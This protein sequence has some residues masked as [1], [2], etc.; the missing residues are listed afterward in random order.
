MKQIL[1]LLWAAALLAHDV[2]AG[3]A[4]SGNAWE[5]LLR[6]DARIPATS[7]QAGR[8][9]DARAIGG[10][11]ARYSFTVPAE[12]FAAIHVRQ[13][14]VDMIAALFDPDGRLL[15]VADFNESGGT[16]HL[17]LWSGQGGTY[18]VQ[19]RS[20][21]LAA[22]GAYAIW[23]SPP[24]TA[25]RSAQSRAAQLMR[26]WY[27]PNRPGAAVAV[28]RGGQVVF[29][30]ARGLASVEFNVPITTATAFDLA[31]VS[32]QFTAY[33]IAMLTDAGRLSLDDDIRTYLADIPDFGRKITVRNLIDHTSGLRDW[34]TS[35]G[36]MGYRLEEGLT[37]GWVMNFVSHQNDL[38]FEPGT[39]FYYSNTGY[40]LLAKIVERVTGKPFAGWM[41]GNLFLPLGM[42][43]TFFN[44]DFHAVIKGK[45]L[46]YRASGDALKLYAGNSTAVAGSSSLH[47]SVDDLVKWVG[48]LRSGKVGG[49]QVLSIIGR[50]AALQGG[51]NIDY[52]F[53]AEPTTYK[54]LR[55]IQY[56]GLAAG[57][58]ITIKRFID[59]DVSVIYLANDGD[60][61]AYDHAFELGELFLKSVITPPIEI[62]SDTPTDTTSAAAPAPAVAPSLPDYEGVYYSAPLNTAV[63]VRV[64][65]AKLEMLLGRKQTIALVHQSKDQFAAGGWFLQRLEFVRG[66]QG[67]VEGVRLFEDD[68]QSGHFKRVQ[69]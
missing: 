27:E 53:G 45:A 58:R 26:S 1:L 32:K 59:Q 43:A 33:A 22:D 13:F 15:R 29:R 55:V 44:E 67:S 7:L 63:E 57:Y 35:F 24:E 40:V 38:S 65:D 42:H 61:A 18:T 62:P 34:D 5:R 28:M 69:H 68:Q 21:N 51:E 47:S 11:V 37:T 30:G 4:A 2:C 50:K 25:G 60:D 23:M 64:R 46:S 39:R 66:P 31:S 17:P 52:A 54:N 3:T 41:R 12:K 36:L 10:R 8:R 49:A 6:S 19:V 48:N 56:Q 14:D 9:I 20:T 16:E